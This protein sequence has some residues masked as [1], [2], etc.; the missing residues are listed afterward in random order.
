MVVNPI[1]Y[2]LLKLTLLNLLGRLLL[3]LTMFI[4][5]FIW[6]VNKRRRYP[7]LPSIKHYTNYV[8]VTKS[9]WVQC[10]KKFI[11]ERSMIICIC[12]PKFRI[13][14]NFGSVFFWNIHVIMKINMGL[15]QTFGCLIFLTKINMCSCVTS[16]LEILI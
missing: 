5:H 4:I 3:Q 14:V 1:L 16:L 7:P 15:N 9:V 10:E 2:F 8:N 13:L 6:I 12:M 11:P